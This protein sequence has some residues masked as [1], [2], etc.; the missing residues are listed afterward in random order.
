MTEIFI[1]LA[2]VAIGVWAKKIGYPNYREKRDRQ[3]AANQVKPVPVVEAEP[4]KTPD[5]VVVKPE[6]PIKTIP[7]PRQEL[8][9]HIP[10]DINKVKW[11]HGQGVKDW[12]VTSHLSGVRVTA[13][14]TDLKHSKGGVWPKHVLDVDRNDNDVVVDSSLWMFVEIKGTWY[15]ATYDYLRPDQRFKMV[16]FVGMPAHTK[17]SPIKDFEFRKGDK[18]YVMVSGLARN[19]NHKNIK[20]R[21]NLVPVT[22]E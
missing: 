1:L 15:A 6:E 8:S 5:P 3:K 22:F 9:G 21:S 17:Q 18:G 19:P 14:R 7:R 12:P 11:L 16:G 20:E 4:V 13:G 10:F 2:I